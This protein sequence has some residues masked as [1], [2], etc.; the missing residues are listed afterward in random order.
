V[1]TIVEI[2]I[3]DDF[4]TERSILGGQPRHRIVWA[5]EQI[6]HGEGP[7]LTE[8]DRDDVF[9]ITPDGNGNDIIAFESPDSDLEGVGSA[10]K[11]QTKGSTKLDDAV[12]REVGA[13]W[14]D[15]PGCPTVRVYVSGTK[16]GE[17]RPSVPNDVFNNPQEF[18]IGRGVRQEML[19]GHITDLK[20]YSFDVFCN[21]SVGVNAER[22]L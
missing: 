2:T 12:T 11:G 17:L 20:I 22:D 14:D 13:S 7:D 6:D 4:T 10:T 19:D 21:S 16:E 18:H 1:S 5:I 15:T 8:G 9:Y 3:E